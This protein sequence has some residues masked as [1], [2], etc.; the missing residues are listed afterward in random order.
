MFTSAMPYQPTTMFATLSSPG[1][2]AATSIGRLM[3][4][5]SK[6]FTSARKRFANKQNR[7]DMACCAASSMNLP[8]YL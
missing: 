8:S 7:S 1:Q 2:H 3:S 6:P 4:G 5:T